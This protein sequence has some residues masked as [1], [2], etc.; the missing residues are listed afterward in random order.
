MWEAIDVENQLNELKLPIAADALKYK[1]DQAAKN[2]STYL[3]FLGSLLDEEINARRERAFKT[4]SQLANLPF[5]KTLANF[6]FSFQP[7]INERQIRE[8]ANLNFLTE[9]TN[10]LLLGP[11]GVG[12]YAK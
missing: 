8:L 10:I 11:P 9:A 1:L 12:N 6:D 7:S 3:E 2:N 5:H 4:R